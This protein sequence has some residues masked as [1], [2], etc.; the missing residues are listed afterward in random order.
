M[1]DFRLFKDEL[2][3]HRI[4]YIGRSLCFPLSDYNRFDTSFSS[5]LGFVNPVEFPTRNDVPA[6]LYVRYRL[7]LLP[8]VY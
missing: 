7:F 8:K 2:S 5:L 4:T 6:G 1:Y 3:N